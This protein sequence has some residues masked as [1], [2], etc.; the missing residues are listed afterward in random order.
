M[1]DP[2]P[3]GS[4]DDAGAWALGALGED[5]AQAYAAHLEGCAECRDDVARLRVPVDLLGLGAPQVAPRAELRERIMAVVHA[6]AQ[7]LAAAGPE[8]DRVP[9][10]PSARRSWW[11]GRRPP[12]AG[13]GVLAAAACAAVLALIV[14]GGGGGDDGARTLTGT[15]AQGAQIVVHVDGDGHAVLH[16]AR[17]PAS[18]TG[19]VYEVW[20]V[21]GGVAHATHALFDVPADGR[22]QVEVPEKISGAERLMVTDEPQGG[23]AMPTGHVVV[24][25]N[26][27]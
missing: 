12:A 5:E 21:R 4:A 3:C 2:E 27:A 14:F 20:I 26:F 6:E 16:L 18:P 23:S 11:S 10:A 19:R 25:A 8:A 13:S 1:S 22:A 24:N 7:L 9:A 17:I 15:G